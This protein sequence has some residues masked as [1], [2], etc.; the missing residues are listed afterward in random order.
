MA[1]YFGRLKQSLSGESKLAPPKYE[2]EVVVTYEVLLP[3]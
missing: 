1:K 2:A 3:N